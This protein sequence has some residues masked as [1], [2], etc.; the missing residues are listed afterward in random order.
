MSGVSKM[1]EGIMCGRELVHD[2]FKLH[3]N[4]NKTTPTEVN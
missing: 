2:S 3:K 4:I 1:T